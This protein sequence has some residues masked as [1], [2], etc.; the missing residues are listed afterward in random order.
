MAAPRPFCGSQGP[1]CCWLQAET[2]PRQ[3]DGYIRSTADQRSREP[4]ADDPGFGLS[5][6][7]RNLEGEGSHIPNSARGVR[8]G[9]SLFLSGP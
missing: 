2:N 5:R 7:L 8:L 9:D 1:G 3:A 6:R 4:R